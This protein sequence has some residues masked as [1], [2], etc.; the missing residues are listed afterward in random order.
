MRVRG[1]GPAGT[2]ADAARSEA[3][4]GGRALGLQESKECSDVGNDPSRT[5]S[6]Y[7]CAA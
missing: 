1:P 7:A 3:R 6:P 4:C 2:T 5:A